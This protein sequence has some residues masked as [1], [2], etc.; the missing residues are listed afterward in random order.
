[1]RALAWLGRQGTRA[2]AALVLLGIA[3]PPIGAL[4]KPFVAEAIFVLLTI[5]FVRVDTA[6]MQ[7]YLQRPALALAATGWTA[8][9]I[10][11]ALGTAGLLARLDSRDPELFL[12]VMLQA[13]ASPMM[14]APSFAALIGLDATLVL[15]TLILASACTPLTAPL[16]S[17]AFV[18][19]S[20]E[21]SRLALGVRLF[22]IIAGA[23]VAGLVIRR[24]AG[25]VSIQRRKDEIDGLNIVVAFVFVAAVMEHVAARTF[26]AP[27]TMLGLVAGAVGIFAV[28]FGLTALVFAWAGRDRAFALGFVTSQRNMGLMLAATGGALPETT[29]LYFAAA[30]F[31]IYLSPLLLKSLAGRTGIRT[32]A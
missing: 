21:L 5:A 18:G 17:H 4:L 16:I 11:T 26:E 14:A 9:I 23:A 3:A 27:A 22:A 30:Q 20:L 2:V 7:A 24:L 31:P 25:V 1:M 6:A 28:V 13:V 8:L 29:W 32:R 15:V 12:A 10:P 19:T